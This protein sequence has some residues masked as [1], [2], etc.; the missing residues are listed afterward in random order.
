MSDVIVHHIGGGDGLRWDSAIIH[1]Y[2]PA[3]SS[4]VATKDSTTKTLKENTV[5]GADSEYFLI[6]KLADYGIWTITATLSGDTAQ[7]TVNITSNI[8]YII[9]IAYGL[10]L[11]DHGDPCTAVTGGWDTVKYNDQNNVS[12]S[13]P[14]GTDYTKL[15]WANAKYSQGVW[16]THN[17][18]ALGGYTSIELEYEQTNT[19]ASD[20]WFSIHSAQGGH[21]AYT[22]KTDLDSITSG[23]TIKTLNIAS[24]QS[25]SYYVRI[26][27]ATRNTVDTYGE[28]T[29][30]VYSIRL[31]E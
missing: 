4:V 12:Q 20:F 26:G 9:R 8:E 2:A 23:K 16:S 14:S 7:S 19:P 11:S 31:K 27:G 6:V 3:G 17:K 24:Y 25:G 5:S 18:I 28:L 29:I 10:L 13:H 22:A 15:T 21:Q 1:I 30:K